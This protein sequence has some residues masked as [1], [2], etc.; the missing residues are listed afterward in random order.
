MYIDLTM[1]VSKRTP[2]FPGN[3]GMDLT[4]VNTLE[5]EGWLTNRISI[6]THFATHIDAPCHMIKGAKKLDD[7]PIEY[8]IGSAMI[9]TVKDKIFIEPEDFEV[10]Q[11]H[12]PFIFFRT[13][14]SRKWLDSDYFDNNPV[15]TEATANKIVQCG[16]R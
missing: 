13:D 9:V 5:N 14:Y 10:P 3:P 7:Y 15:I 11:N 6:N 4:P 16:F 8:F 1:E 2:V 12:P